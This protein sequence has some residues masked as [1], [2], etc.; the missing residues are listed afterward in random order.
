MKN[1]KGQEIK[2]VKDGKGVK[3]AVVNPKKENPKK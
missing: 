1:A 3:V 2:V